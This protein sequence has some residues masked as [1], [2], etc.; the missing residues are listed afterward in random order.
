M[1]TRVAT[2]KSWKSLENMEIRRSLDESVSERVISFHQL[3]DKEDIP[4]VFSTNILSSDALRLFLKKCTAECESEILFFERCTNEI[5]WHHGKAYEIDWQLVKKNEVSKIGRDAPKQDEKI[6]LEKND[7]LSGESTIVSKY[8]IIKLCR[9]LPSFLVY[10]RKPAELVF[11][12]NLDGYHAPTLYR[13]MAK[14][15]DGHNLIFVI[16]T[17]KDVFGALISANLHPQAGFFGTGE[18]LLFS[19]EP[20]VKAYCWTGENEFFI[21]CDNHGFGF[22]SGRSENIYVYN[23]FKR[24]Q[25][26]LWIVVRQDTETR[27]HGQVRNLLKRFFDENGRKDRTRNRIPNTPR[28]SVE[29]CLCKR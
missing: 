23:S 24:L 1:S 29:F 22:G 15:E 28:R 13:K 14:Y 20:C 5:K 21:H 19:V 17:A 10:G 27:Q 2:K 6:E 26:F 7:L 25:R 3:S 16:S 12:T 11:S 8:D 9:H 4:I 18:S